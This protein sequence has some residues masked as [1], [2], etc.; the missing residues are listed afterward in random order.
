MTDDQRRR[1]RHGGLVGLVTLAG[2]YLMV[3][4]IDRGRDV[5]AFSV[6][7]AVLMLVL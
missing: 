5:A 6:V 3:I 2:V 4:A 1:L 7:Y